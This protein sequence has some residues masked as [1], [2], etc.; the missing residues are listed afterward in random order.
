V[1]ELVN[2]EAISGPRYPEQTQKEIDTE[3]FA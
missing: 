1:G 3:E 2:Q